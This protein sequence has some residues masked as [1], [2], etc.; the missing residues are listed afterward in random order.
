MTKNVGQLLEQL[1]REHSGKML[2]YLVSLTN[3]LNVAEEIWHDTLETALP[4]WR[5][6]PPESPIAWLYKVARNK[7]IDRIRHQQMSLQKGRLIQAL[8]CQEEQHVVANWDDQHFLDDQLKLVFTCC[9]PSLDIDKQVSLTLSVIC[10]LT[11]QQIADALLLQK[12][13]LEQRL[14][15]AKRKLKTAGIP[16]VIPQENQ[17]QERLSAVLKAIYLVFNAADQPDNNNDCD[18]V[19]LREEALRLVK[20]LQALLPD[21]PEVDGLQALMLFHLA[22]HKARYDE[23]GQI[24]LL[25]K[26]DRNR[27]DKQAIREADTIL[28]AVLKRRMPGSYQIQAAIQGL[29][30]LSPSPEETDWLQIEALYHLLMAYDDNPIIKL[31]AA[32]ATS[33]SRD[34]ASGIRMLEE[35]EEIEQLKHYSLMYGAK[36]DMLARLNQRTVAKQYYQKALRCATKPAEV[37]FYQKK[38]SDY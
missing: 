12:T 34:V 13:T 23:Q 29:H 24:V 36:A 37:S 31:N 19:D 28:Q 6:H 11:T 35:C 10:G 14:T 32:V 17:L 20:N 18:A 26:Q 22:R 5:N 25:E 33:M 38:L 8:A 30:C 1:Y 27:W 21:Q 4:F 7:T 3:D 9:H 16:F 15:R 2:A